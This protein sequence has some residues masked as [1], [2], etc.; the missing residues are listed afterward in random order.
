MLGIRAPDAGLKIPLMMFPMMPVVQIM[1]K[2]P[3]ALDVTFIYQP[4]EKACYEMEGHTVKAISLE[5]E[6]PYETI[7]V[8]MQAVEKNGG[9]SWVVDYHG[10]LY[11]ASYMRAFL[12]E[13][14]AVVE[15]I[16]RNDDME[17]YL[18]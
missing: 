18:H 12:E 2:Y 3:N 14:N 6:M 8:V 15:A 5:D 7:K 16:L 11:S 1:E 9:I 17:K 4:E 13:L 10:N